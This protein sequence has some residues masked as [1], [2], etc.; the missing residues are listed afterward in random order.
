M[1]AGHQGSLA[2]IRTDHGHDPS[3]VKDDRRRFGVAVD[4][5]FRGSVYV[6]AGDRSAHDHNVFYQRDN[7]W[8]LRDR[9]SNIRKW[10]DGNQHDLMRIFMNHFDD[11]IR[12]EARIRLAFRWRQ[13]NTGQ[14]VLAMP[15]LSGDKFLVQWV[16]GSR[17]EER[18]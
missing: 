9:Q 13:F 14:A 11:E 15:V 16:L 7:R 17:S 8:I 4:V 12:P 6:S 5:G 10:T 18:R 3:S 1:L 2:D